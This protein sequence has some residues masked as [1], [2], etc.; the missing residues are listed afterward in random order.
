MIDLAEGLAHSRRNGLSRDRADGGS[1][2]RVTRPLGHSFSRGLGVGLVGVIAGLAVLLGSTS[3]AHAAT[4]ILLGAGNRPA[5]AVNGAGTAFIAYLD[6]D[7]DPTTSAPDAVVHYCRLPRGA[8]VC[9]HRLDFALEGTTLTRPHVFVEGQTVRIL[10]FRYGLSGANFAADYVLSS[11]DGGR[12]F[13][14]PV[15]AGTVN[16]YDAVA[17]PG[18]NGISLVGDKGGRN[19]LYQR[20]DATSPFPVDINGRSTLGSAEL[21]PGRDA[22]SP[23]VE[24]VNPTTPLVTFNFLD[25]TAAFRVFGGT[26]EV[27][28]AANW[29][30]AQVIA[31]DGEYGQL[32]QGPSGL[33]SQLDAENPKRLD[34]RRYNGS[35]FGAPTSIPIAEGGPTS[36]LAQDPGGMLFSLWVENSVIGGPRMRYASSPDGVSWRTA[37]LLA[38]NTI[39][40]QMGEVRAGAAPDHLGYAVVD[41]GQGNARQVYA[42]PLAPAPAPTP[43]RGTSPGDGTPQTPP[44]APAISAP[45][46]T[47]SA[48]CV[49]R[50]CPGSRRGTTVRFALSKPARVRLRIDRR[51]A[52]RRDGDRCRRPTRRNRNARR[53][54][55]YVKVGGFSRPGTAGA[56]RVRFSGKIGNRALRRGR[57]RLTI[58]AIDANSA[59]SAPKR[60]SFRVH[61][62]NPARD[63]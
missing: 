14:A 20:V 41:S 36:Y 59:R 12:T 38:F 15:A 57:Y 46:L 54:S 58:T 19:G 60:I 3:P 22:Y 13:G 21:S 25:G 62:P 52:G 63:R 9:D 17:G 53:C 45:S 48:F 4:P 43:P 42:V 47:R 30:P 50:R 16:P 37:Q 32:A 44:G 31:R 2:R 23:A 27:N 61:P 10:A 5:V 34:V 40:R 29:S 49:G 18:P 51:V 24:L 1:A 35:T 11:T 39:D 55:R 8:T 7:D 6:N 28:D 56:N 26:G 33:F